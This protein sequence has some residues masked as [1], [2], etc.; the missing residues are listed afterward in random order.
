MPLT[1]PIRRRFSRMSPLRM[2]LNSWP[3]TPCSSSRERY[4]Q[5]AG[6]DGHDGVARL[7]PRGEGVDARFVVQHVDRR[8][9]NARGQGHF[10]DH[11]QE[12]PFGQIGGLRIDG[13]S[14][15]HQRDRFAAG[16]KLADFVQAAQ[17][18]DQQRSRRN[19]QEKLGL[20]EARLP[21]NRWAQDAAPVPPRQGA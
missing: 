17:R 5:R 3:M 12:P 7:V 9:G 18:N 2:W 20:P 10:L 16:R 21:V 8:D 14:A 15:E 4:L 11:V 19:A 1:S 6:G 13:P